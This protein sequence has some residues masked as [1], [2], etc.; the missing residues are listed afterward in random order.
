MMRGHQKRG[1]AESLRLRHQIIG[2][3]TILPEFSL[4]RMK[5]RDG[6]EDREE[7]GRVAELMT[8][9]ARACEDR[10]DLGA[11]P[12]LHHPKRQPTDH[13]QPQLVLN[14][15]RPLRHP[16]QHPQAA[17]GKRERLAERKE[18]DGVPSA[19]QIE[20]RAGPELA[21]NLEERR[22]TA[23]DGGVLVPM[24]DDER[25][26]DTAAQRHA[27]R[28]LQ[29]CIQRVLIQHVHELVLQRQRQIG[30]L[31]LLDARDEHIHLLQRVEALL[32]LRRVHLERFRDDGRVEL[33]PLHAR[34]KQQPAVNLVEP[35][36]LPGDH[37]ADGC[38]QLA[39]RFGL[40]SRQHPASRHARQGCPSRASSAR[41]PP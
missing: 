31:V 38:R 27:A 12:S 18:S 20:L 11:R 10:L 24:M 4:D 34:G 29:G 8:Q 35:F 37:A 36:D 30:K 32:H 15:L 39:E 19:R 9:L 16:A 6:P 13:L 23:R 7:L 1:I 21:G 41:R 14:P 40:G 25:A 5:Q 22:E 2:A 33:V 28:G 26:C 3:S 17:F